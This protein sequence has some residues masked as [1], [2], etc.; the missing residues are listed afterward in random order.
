MDVVSRENLRELAEKTGQW[1]V[2]VYLPT[3]R[4]SRESQQDRTLLKNLLD[5]AES[6]LTA[7]ALRGP[8]ARQLLATAR[9]L[10]EDPAQ[11]VHQGDGLALLLA[12]GLT[13]I[14]RLPL[15]FRECLIVN[16]R[17]H[18]RPLLP[19]LNGDGKYYVLAL[20][21]NQPR[22]FQATHYSIAEVDS[23]RLPASLAE[24][25]KYDQLEK[26][27]NLH[28]HHQP[29][30]E[31]NRGEAIF[32][33]HGAG[34]DD[35]S[36][37]RLK[38]YFRKI[39]SGLHE[40]LRTEQAPLVLAGVE[41][42]FPIYREANTYNHLLP[43]GIEGSPSHENLQELHQKAWKVIEP[44]F[45]KKQQDAVAAYRQAIGTGRASG[46]LGEIL[47]AAG[48]GRVASLFLT[49]DGH[50]WGKFNADNGAT[51]FH[52]SQQDGDEDLLDCAARRA[53]LNGGAIYVLDTAQMPDG[54]QAAAIFRY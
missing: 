53:L 18:L 7:R 32:H 3:H 23:A 5:Q 31:R 49:R 35:Q 39:D 8:D 19:L 37:R 48:Q 38:E 29:G 44:L 43:Q 30:P 9:R 51:Q 33:G 27:L 6:Q 11:W 25:L 54:R 36:K 41:Y 50:Q 10:Q 46:D 42:Y 15:K 17:F 34:G 13:R 47:N 21:K 1:C 22:L 12:P 2:S 14:Y 26:E 45:Q 4:S 28:T 20:A 24:A 16:E 52:P 40:L